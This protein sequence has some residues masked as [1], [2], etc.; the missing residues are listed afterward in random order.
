MEVF[1]ERM[2]AA[3]LNKDNIIIGMVIAHEFT[4]E[5][6][7]MLIKKCVILQS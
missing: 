7:L 1:V 2:L 3:F 4:L 5:K 6:Q